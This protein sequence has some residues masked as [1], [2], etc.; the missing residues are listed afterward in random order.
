MNLATT[1][2]PAVPP[3][4]KT[5]PWH[6]FVMMPLFEPPSDEGGAVCSGHMPICL[7]HISPYFR[8]YLFHLVLPR[9]IRSVIVL[10]ANRIS[11]TV[12]RT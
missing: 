2:P 1:R 10:S 5:Q 11:A 7:Y 8:G 12:R 3:S 6:A 9:V 4:G